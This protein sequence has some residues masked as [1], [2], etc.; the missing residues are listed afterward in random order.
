[1][2]VLSVCIYIY[3]CASHICLVLVE[4]IK[5]HKSPRT[6]VTGSCELL[7]GCWKANLGPLQE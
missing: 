4:T 6:R 2:C 5:G 1:M 7:F 3:T